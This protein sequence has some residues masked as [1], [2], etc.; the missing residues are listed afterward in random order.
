M[1][2]TQEVLATCYGHASLSPVFQKPSNQGTELHGKNMSYDA[3]H[4]WVGMPA[5]PIC[6]SL[7]KWLHLIFLI[8]KMRVLIATPREHEDHS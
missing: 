5:L 4:V 7:G 3:R 8:C 1:V 6:M 2:S